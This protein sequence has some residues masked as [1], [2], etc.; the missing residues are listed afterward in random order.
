MTT[1]GGV[2]MSKK[3]SGKKTLFGKALDTHHI[4]YTK[5]SW[6]SAT[7]DKL[8]AHWYCIVE[9]PKGTVHHKIHEKVRYIPVPKNDNIRFALAQLDL[10]EDYGAIRSDDPIEKRLQ[11]LAGLFDCTDQPTA[12]ALRKQIEAVREA[13]GLEN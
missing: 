1:K 11:L 8:R 2:Y 12:D 7:A 9:I 4:F 5:V 6:T 13:K 10:L 3:K